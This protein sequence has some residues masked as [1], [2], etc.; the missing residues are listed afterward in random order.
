MLKC[1]ETI[2][3]AS[4]GDL[5]IYIPGRINDSLIDVNGHF[6]N[7]TNNPNNIFKGTEPDDQTIRHMRHHKHL[8]LIHI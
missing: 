6:K 7:F 3:Q 4:L 2:A 5:D 8:S 1:F